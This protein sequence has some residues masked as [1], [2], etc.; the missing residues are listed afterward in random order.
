MSDNST[1][2]AQDKALMHSIIQRVA[3]GPELSKDISQD[4]ARGGMRAILDGHIDPVQAG[5]FLIGLRMKR[6]TP[7]ENRGV[8]DGIIDCTERVTAE[9]DE[10]VDIGDPYDGYNRTLPASPFLPA[11]MAACGIPAVSHGMETVSPK[12][13][14]T[15]RQVMRAAGK[16]D[17]LSPQQAATQIANKDIGWAYVDQ[18]QFCPKLNALTDFRTLVI[19]RP[20]ITTVETETMPIRARGKT[21]HVCGYVHKPY[22]PVYAMLAAHSGFDSALLVRGIEGGVIP[23]LR[24]TGK[25]IS[26]EG[27]TEVRSAEVEPKDLG[28]EQELRAVPI[29]AD[30]PRKPGSNDEV[31]A[32]FLSEAVA[33]AAV[34]AGLAALAGEKGITYD[35]LVYGGANILWHLK[36]YETLAECADAVRAVLDS[37]EALK[38]FNASV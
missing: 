9:V 17:S 13:G 19:K 22:P 10:L 5:I 12:F 21:H 32:P 23:S 37:G 38:R 35:A 34:E 27:E 20:T 31:E 14:V 7:D 2:V 24:Q 30:L 28:I 3:T 16:D 26:Y 4:E 15:H 36:R 8:L 29:P 18:S 33:K 6:E 11:V 1:Q 25:I